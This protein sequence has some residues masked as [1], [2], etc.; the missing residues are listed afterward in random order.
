V[1]PDL[2][3]RGGLVHDGSGEPAVLGDVAI[4]GD[5]IVAVGRVATRGVEEIDASGQIKAPGFI[6]IHSHSDFTLLVDPRALSSIYQGVTTEVVGNCGFGCFPI[7][8]PVPSAAS[9][10]G[11]HSDPPIDWT[12][13][14]GYL[15][16]LEQARPAVNVLSLTPN[17]QLRMAA[18]D[19]TD[20]CADPDALAAMVQ[21]LEQTLEEGSWGY[22]TGLEYAAEAAATP[23]E[24]CALCRV[25]ARRGGLYA[26]HTRAR[27]AGAVEA[28]A[29]ALDTAARAEVRLQIAHLLPRSGLQDGRRC[30]ELVEAARARGQDVG[31]DMHTRLHGL[32]HLAA[33]LPAWAREGGPAAV[34]A[35]LTDPAERARMSGVRS[36][37]SAGGDWGRV[38]LYD[39]HR[40]PAYSRRSIAEIAAARG[41]APFD[42][43]CDLL[44]GVPDDLTSLMVLIAAYSPE[45]QDEVFAH[46]LCVP[47]SDATALCPDGPLAGSA[48]HGAYT[49]AAFFW[50]RMVRKTI[51]LTPELAIRKLSAQ[52]ADRLGLT[53]RGRLAVGQYA[54]VAVFD[55]ETYRDTGTLFAPSQ[56]AA[57][58]V[59]VL[60]N[61]RFAMRHGRIMSDRT[62]RIIRRQ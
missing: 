48:F 46:P 23:E 54:D 34:Y 55:P 25:T 8:D 53:D 29:E 52:P 1:S 47:A 21:L 38:I 62:G 61:G 6:D 13:A 32:T 20:R 37:L 17:A 35:R 11:H 15:A 50:R 5:R 42:A 10:Y 41:Q 26:T 3:I 45:Q 7:R 19:R 44:A 36:I 9:I 18:M 2:V 12:T 60:V 28:V 39:T 57:G 59:H 22:S 14:A 24:I 4:A 27:D 49:W 30:I 56:P 40:W 16:R 33:A 51:A 43:V 31:F 58:V